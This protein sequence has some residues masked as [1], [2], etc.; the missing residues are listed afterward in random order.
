MLPFAP[1]A[2]LAAHKQQLFPRMSPHKTVKSP[3][4]GKLLPVIAGDLLQQGALA[5]HHFVVTQRQNKLLGIGIDEGKSQLPVVIAA[6]YRLLGE[7]I[8][9]V[10]H[11]AHIPFEAEPQAAGSDIPANAIPGGGLFGNHDD[12]RVL[13]VET[14]V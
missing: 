1:L 14:R 9:G 4:R 6:M 10:V 13:M 3:Q 12:P 5:M 11:P 7:I 8:Q 2:K